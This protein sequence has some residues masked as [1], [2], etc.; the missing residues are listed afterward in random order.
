MSNKL[1][2]I[3]D[4]TKSY[5]E[6]VI[7]DKLNLISVRTNFSHSLVLVDVEKQHYYVFSVDLRH[8][9]PVILF[10]MMEHINNPYGNLNIGLKYWII[11][12]AILEI[13]FIFFYYICFP[14]RITVIIFYGIGVVFSIANYCVGIFRNG[15]A[16]MPSDIPA[17]K[18]AMNVSSNY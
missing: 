11:N 9:T 10:L 5:D 1:I 18:T 17:L 16:I 12:V 3:I 6:N 13:I 2:D 15:N 8:R 7:L 4:I 14:Y